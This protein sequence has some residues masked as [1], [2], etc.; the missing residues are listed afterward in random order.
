MSS[1]LSISIVA[2]QPNRRLLLRTMSCVSAAAA[3]VKSQNNATRVS[4]RLIDNSAGGDSGNRLRGLVS[5]VW[6]G[7]LGPAEVVEAQS[8]L[9][10]G[11]GHNLALRDTHADYH[12]VLNPDVEVRRT[13]LDA[14]LQFMQEHDDV[15]L[16]SPWAIDSAG[17]RQYLCKRYPT[18][19]DLFLRGFGSA[20]LRRLFARRL[21]RYEMRGETEGTELM[22][23]PIVS[24]CFMFVRRDVLDAVGGFSPDYFLYFE[25]FDL[26]LRVSKVARIAY[27][28]AVRIVH[29]GGDA[30]RKGLKH[31]WMFTRSAVTFFNTHGWRWW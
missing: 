3:Y 10:F 5:E 24:G 30:A 9:G 25:D 14:A 28:P 23:V 26:S 21:A 17:Q 12:L 15:G 27:V 31:I 13:G 1:S 6:Q 7:N 29:H 8:N 16:L 11:G 22:D 19:V 20:P 2:F 18:V 4:L